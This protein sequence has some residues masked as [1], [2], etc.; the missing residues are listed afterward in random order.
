MAIIK[1]EKT[2]SKIIISML[3]C[4]SLFLYLL[5]NSLLPIV[6]FVIASI[7]IFLKI[8]RVHLYNLI[9]ILLPVMF[10]IHVPFTI[11][12]SMADFILP[13]LLWEYF[14]YKYHDIREEKITNIILRYGFILMWVMGISLINI[15]RLHDSL[16][17][18]GIAA[19]IKIGICLAYGIVTLKYLFD[20][21]KEKFLKVWY[22]AG[23]GFAILMIVGVLAYYN[24]IDLGLTFAGTFRAT[25]TFEDPNLAA[26]YLFLVF[27][28]VTS[29]CLM[30]K[31]Y[32][33]L[34]ISTL[35][36]F[37]CILLTSS[38]GALV[39]FSFGSVALLIILIIRMDFKSLFK[40][41][42]LYI[43][44]IFILVFL[45]NKYEFVRDIFEPIFNR[46]D[47]FTSNINGDH[48]LEHRKFLW[49]TALELGWKYPILGVGTEQFRPAASVFT[50]QN[51]W[52]IV[53]NTY[54]TFWAETGLVGL[55]AF[56]WL[57]IKIF[58]RT[59]KKI[60]ENKFTILYLFSMC[61]IS[62]SMYSISLQNFRVLWVFLAYLLYDLY[63]L[64]YIDKKEENFYDT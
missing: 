6:I 48:S 4:F 37:T 23:M 58:F 2:I 52:N 10:Y 28:F 24:G 21:G 15:I 34:V 5:T 49:N 9:A 43:V 57:P 62:V 12:T 46:L 20:N 50:N 54:L 39:A 63:Y 19:I 33:R 30:N 26:A 13:F 44:I 22:Y 51:I 31:K 8:Y 29:Y 45:Y 36:I 38:K 14:T 25:G 35:I 27:T 16:L 17:I 60:N 18:Q 56:L 40:L 42:F 59:L 3:F 7:L 47:E 64:K 11:N 32:F 41:V 1:S 55:T 61:S 53:H